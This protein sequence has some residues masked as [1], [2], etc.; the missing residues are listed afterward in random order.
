MWNLKNYRFGVN[1][2]A[3]VLFGLIMIPN[4][5]WF[6]HP[7]PYDVLRIMTHAPLLELF[8]KVLQ[9]LMVASL[10]FLVNREFHPPVDGKIF[11]GICLSYFLYC[12]GWCFY[13]LGFAGP[14][15]ILILCIAPSLC[16]LLEGWGRKNGPGF[17]F[18]LLFLFF[19]TLWGV[20]KFLE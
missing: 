19:H 4:L 6:L 9:P 18:S 11:V 13:Y 17:V 16:F 3:F 20:L 15:V 2:W 7:A 8:V 10:I 1:T 5:L 14:A 12:V